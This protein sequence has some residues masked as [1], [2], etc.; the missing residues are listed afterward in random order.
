MSVADQW[1]SNK[2]EAAGRVLVQVPLPMLEALA[3]GDFANARKMSQYRL[4]NYLES[5]SCRSVWRRRA[6]QIKVDETDAIWVTR[7]LI[8]TASGLAV[9]RAGFHG[10]PN[11]DGM[12]EVGYAIDEEYR[13]QGYARAA[14]IIMLDVASRDSSVKIVRATIQPSNIASRGLVAQYGFK[15]VGEQW[16]DEDGLE[17]IF[18]VPV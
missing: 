18:E 4:T 15:E 10:R 14:L 7:L 13:R 5:E 1:E 17:T 6:T 2:S 9:G 11:E 8:D 3:E 16:D 12:V